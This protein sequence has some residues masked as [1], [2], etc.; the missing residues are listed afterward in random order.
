MNN[1]N[2]LSFFWDCYARFYDGL[3]HTIFYRRLVNQ[4]AECVPVGTAT[5]LD[6]GCGTGNLLMAIRQRHPSIKVYGIDFSEAMLKR[7]RAKSPDGQF[8]PG[9]LNAELPYADKS[10]DVVTCV[11]VLY[12]VANPERTLAELRRV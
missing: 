8:L 11:N 2:T 4:V 1:K 6:A 10:F 3:L 7:A 9:D 12:A 5:L